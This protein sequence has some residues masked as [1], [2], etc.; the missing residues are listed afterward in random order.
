MVLQ[1]CINKV[2]SITLEQGKTM[3]YGF[4]LLFLCIA[5]RGNIVHFALVYKVGK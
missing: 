4:K 1:I 5:L 3:H 2:N